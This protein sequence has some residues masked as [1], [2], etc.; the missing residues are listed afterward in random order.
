MTGIG[1]YSRRCLNAISSLTPDSQFILLSPKNTNSEALSE[2]PATAQLYTPKWPFSKGL[3][4][5]LFRNYCTC[6]F[7]RRQRLELFHGL[8]NE[9]PFFIHKSGCQTIVTIHDLIFLRHPE[10][11]KKT[12]RRI[13]KKKTFYACQ[14]ADMIVAV[15]EKTK[16]DIMHF[17]GVEPERIIVIYQSYNPIFN[18]TVPANMV[19]LKCDA[20]NLPDS[21][22]L[23]VGTIEQRKNQE[24]LIKSLPYLPKHLSLVLVGKATPYQESLR[25]YALKQKLISRVYFRNNVSTEDLPALYQGA[26]MMAYMSRYEGFG[27][28]IVEALASGIPVIAAT[29]SSLEEAGGPDSVYLSP[30]DPNKLAQTIIELDGNEMLRKRMVE[31][32]KEYVKR[33]NDLR[34]GEQLV[35]LY[36]NLSVQ[37]YTV[38]SLL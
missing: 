11:Y 35:Q 24:V 12:D 33:F 25:Q 13:L 28:P 27:I 15:S 20:Y 8:S 17:Y 30:D 22:I 19:K 23:C 7:I 14:K 34:L 4:Y 16:S 10:W 31:R 26:R 38:P 29:G 1:N 21:Y 6:F 18:L 9:V 2:I 36:K 32:G 5:E 3:L 37:T